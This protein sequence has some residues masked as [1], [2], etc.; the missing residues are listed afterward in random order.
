MT[1]VCRVPRGHSLPGN[2]PL[3]F[4]PS[5]ITH[6]QQLVFKMAFLFIPGVFDALHDASVR[7]NFMG[8]AAEED[9]PLTSAQVEAAREGQASLQQAEAVVADYEDPSAG[10]LL[11]ILFPGLGPIYQ[12]ALAGAPRSEVVGQIVPLVTQAQDYA[13]ENNIQP[14]GQAKELSPEAAQNPVDAALAQ[15]TQF[16]NIILPVAA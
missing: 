1:V 16:L 14:S 15:A 9:T 12:A 2:T 6:F 7:F 11:G 8:A 10:F 13:Q 4:L 3:R 5:Q